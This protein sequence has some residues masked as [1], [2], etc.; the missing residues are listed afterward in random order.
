MQYK[1]AVSTCQLMPT[2]RAGDSI[3][4][5]VTRIHYSAYGRGEHVILSVELSAYCTYIA[6]VDHRRHTVLFI[7]RI[8]RGG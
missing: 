8:Q 1:L 6:S 4:Y 3:K 7:R 5:R 2:G